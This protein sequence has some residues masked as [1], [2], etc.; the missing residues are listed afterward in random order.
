MA[1]WMGLGLGTS[2]LEL[3][4][5][6]GMGLLRRLGM[7]WLGLGSWLRMGMGLGRLGCWLVYVLV[8]A[9]VLLQSL[10]LRI[11]HGTRR[12]IPVSGLGH[13][14]IAASRLVRGAAS[15]HLE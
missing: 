1:R 12:S 8:L 15:R 6:L 7:G 4:L 14:G 10:G 9:G 11:R 3:G 5:G 2:R 13:A